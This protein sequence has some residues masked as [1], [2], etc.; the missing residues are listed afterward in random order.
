MPENISST[1]IEPLGSGVREGVD[2]DAD[3]A[4]GRER[5]KVKVEEV[6]VAAPVV[7]VDGEEKHQLDERA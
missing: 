6:E 5:R 3:Y 2:K 7:E 1:R 4:L